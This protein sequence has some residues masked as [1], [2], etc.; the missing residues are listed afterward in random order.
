MS[1]LSYFHSH[2][3]PLDVLENEYT[4]CHST[5]IYTEDTVSQPDVHSS[6]QHMQWLLFPLTVAAPLSWLLLP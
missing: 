6:T 3:T 1:I 5:L 2:F 4:R